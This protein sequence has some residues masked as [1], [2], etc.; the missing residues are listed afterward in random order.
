MTTNAISHATANGD[1]HC[2]WYFP[3]PTEDKV[4][5]LYGSIQL[6]DLRR[7][8]GTI[9]NFNGDIGEIIDATTWE[10]SANFPQTFKHKIIRGRLSGRGQEILLFD[11]T[12]YSMGEGSADIRG[13]SAIV[14]YS[15]PEGDCPRFL[16]IE[17]QISSLDKL[18]GLRPLKSAHFPTND[19]QGGEWKATGEPNSSLEWSSEQHEIIHDYYATFRATDPYEFRVRFAPVVRMNRSAPLTL[20]QWFHDWITPLLEIASAATG[21]RETIT[22][23][24]LFPDL[25]SEGVPDY[26]VTPFGGGISQRSYFSSNTDGD[27][28]ESAFQLAPQKLSLLQIIQNWKKQREMQNPLLEIYN[29]SMMDKTQHSRGRFLSTLQCIE[30]LHGFENRERQIERTVK[31]NQKRYSLIRKMESVKN[32]DSSILS[33]KD[34][35]FAKS[36]LGKRPLSGLDTCLVELISQLPSGAPTMK[37]LQNLEIVQEFLSREEE[38]ARSAADAVRLLRND[39]AH[40]N[41]SYPQYQVAE[42][43]DV[44][45]RLVRAHLLRVLG[46]GVE[47]QLRA[48]HPA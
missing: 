37:E 40:G 31:H 14:G 5:T 47:A 3:S 33:S 2:E 6:R 22:H 41:R 44:L 13:S 29:P 24:A 4:S 15:L 16:G 27:D 17:L 1:Y 21:R 10:Y 43:A 35:Q 23:L 36:A 8:T 32:S 11:A 30:A 12:I 9:L 34:L 28:V 20:E 19:W 18:G 42:A 26:R 25:K 7:P 48:L 38:P 39:L 45:H 46:A